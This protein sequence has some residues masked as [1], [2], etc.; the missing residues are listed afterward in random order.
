MKLRHRGYDG[1]VAC[2]AKNGLAG[3]RTVAAH[4][5]Y[6]SARELAE[7]GQH[8]R[9][10]AHCRASNLKIEACTLPLHRVLGHAAIGLG[11]DWTASDNAMDILADA[12]L[13]AMIGKHLADDPTALPVRTGLR[14]ATIDGAR[15]LG[16]DKAI[17]SVEVGKLA[18]LANPRHD[19]RANLLY[20]MSTRCVRDV[21]VD[22]KLLVLRGKLLTPDLA[23]LKSDLARRWPVWK[24]A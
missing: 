11:T 6:R 20:S 24:S 9:S 16:L 23:R 14:M 4:C 5:I 22:G 19:L 21:M 12:R 10:I 3:P 15:A 13:A 18:D 8:G 1:A 17:G 7:W 2:L